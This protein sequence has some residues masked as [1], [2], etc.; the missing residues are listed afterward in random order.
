MPRVFRQRQFALV[1]LQT[2]LWMHACLGQPTG[3]LF[4]KTESGQLVPFR[5]E[6]RATSQTRILNNGSGSVEKLDLTARFQT[7]VSKTDCDYPSC[8]DSEHAWGCGP[9]GHCYFVAKPNNKDFCINM[10]TETLIDESG[11]E[12]RASFCPTP[13]PVG[14]SMLTGP[15]TLQVTATSSPKYAFV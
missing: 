6:A 7:C 10:C 14:P 1:I 5:D 9:A 11:E 12:Y 2:W 15:S 4:L 8:S 13:P 3:N